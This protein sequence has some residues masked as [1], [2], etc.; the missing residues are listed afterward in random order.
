MRS[1][2]IL[3]LILASLT[4]DAGLALTRNAPAQTMQTMLQS[5]AGPHT[6]EEIEGKD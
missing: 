2:I 1:K 3:T 5:T 6:P 4:F